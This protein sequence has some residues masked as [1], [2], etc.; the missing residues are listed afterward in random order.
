M[1]CVRL[2][3]WLW[4]LS[5]VCDKNY[6]RTKS[7]TAEIGLVISLLLWWWRN[8]PVPYHRRAFAF[9]VPFTRMYQLYI[10]K[11][12][13]DDWFEWVTD[14]S[15]D[16]SECSFLLLLL[17]LPF[18]SQ[19]FFCSLFFCSRCSFTRFCSGWEWNEDKSLSVP[20]LNCAAFFIDGR[21]KVGS[22][23]KLIALKPM[24]TG[25]AVGDSADSAL[26]TCVVRRTVMEQSIGV[27][28]VCVNCV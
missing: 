16:K 7:E 9:I 15:P 10:R 17:H 4:V 11:Y 14:S 23:K 3:C 6:C 19:F 26:Y 8:T 28:W 24:R 20:I 2:G 27:V 12:I 21:N 25:E 13:C 22:G 1:L 18:L 5:I